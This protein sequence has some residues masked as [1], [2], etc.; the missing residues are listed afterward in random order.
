MSFETGGFQTELGGYRIHMIADDVLLAGGPSKESRVDCCTHRE[1]EL[2][3]V[4][5]IA[6]WS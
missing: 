4:A 5:P 2:V 3:D 1:H 6:A